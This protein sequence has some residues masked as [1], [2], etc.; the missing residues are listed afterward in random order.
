MVVNT[1]QGDAEAGM[2]VSIPQTFFH[3]SS[4]QGGSGTDPFIDL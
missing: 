2:S 4:E 1:M 3:F